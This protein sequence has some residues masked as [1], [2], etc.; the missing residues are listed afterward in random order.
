[1]EQESIMNRH[2]RRAANA[3]ARRHPGYQLRLLHALN[4]LN[5]A[6]GQVCHILVEHDESCAFEAGGCTCTPNI[7]RRAGAR[8]Q[9]IG[10]DGEVEESPLC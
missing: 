3:K 8:L 9:H 7:T 10:L 4:A 5:L 1:M 6:S 2:A